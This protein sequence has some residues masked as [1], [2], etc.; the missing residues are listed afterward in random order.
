VIVKFDQTKLNEAVEMRMRVISSS[1]TPQ[2]IVDTAA[3]W[4]TVN[5]RKFTPFTT[6]AKIDTELS[7]STRP[8][9]FKSGKPMKTKKLLS[10]GNLGLNAKI[11]KYADVPLVALIIQASS[12]PGSNY[13]QLTNSR[14]ALTNSPFKG[15]YRQQGAALMKA[16]MDRLVK[17]RHSST[18]YLASGWLAPQRILYPLAVRSW[19]RGSSSDAGTGA[20]LSASQSARG[21][22]TPASSGLACFATIENSTGGIG[23][24]ADKQNQA[25]I[26]FGSAPLQQAADLEEAQLLEYTRKAMEKGDY[27]FNEMAK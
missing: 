23:P 2:Q 1:R 19:G 7:V 27:L 9:L 18:H 10:F 16:A 8:K 3:F 13:N 22:A 11:P 24:N 12:N 20:D 6:Q 4:I 14:F 21:S 17:A 5:A 25:L 15:V 26:K